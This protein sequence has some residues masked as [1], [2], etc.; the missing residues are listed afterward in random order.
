MEVH[1]S[2]RSVL[3]SVLS[4]AVIVSALGYFVDIYDLLLFSIIRVPS[5]KALGVLPDRLLDTGVYLL[6]VQMAGMLIGGICWGILGDKKGRRSVLFG[7]ILL[8]SLANIAN[9]LVSD[10]NLYAFFRV[11]AGIGLAG[12]IGAAVT[13]ISE[14]MSKKNRAYGSSIV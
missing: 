9:G 1:A 11:L 12:E 13:L 10:L 3:R 2:G 6:N 8:Y 4:A 5:L 14:V 7:S